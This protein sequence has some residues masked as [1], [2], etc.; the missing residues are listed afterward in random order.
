[1]VDLLLIKTHHIKYRW[2]PMGLMYVAKA[3]KNVG[4]KVKILDLSLEKKPF[5]FLRKQLLN[6][7]PSIVGVGGMYCEFEEIRQ[8]A[9]VTRETLPKTIVVVGGPLTTALLKEILQDKNIDLV[10]LCEGELT[11]QDLLGF[12]DGKTKLEDIKGIVFRKDGKLF[13]TQKREILDINLIPIPAWE[14]IDVP[15]YISR[16]DN[17]FGIENLKMLNI[18]PQRGC[19]YSCVFCD[20]N[21][22]GQ[23]WRPRDPKNIVDEMLF[24]KE[25]YKIEAIMF[26]DDIFDVNKKWVYSFIEELKK[27]NVNM[28]WGCSSRVNHSDYHLYKAMKEVGCCYI[29]YGVEFGTNEMLEK[30]N[31]KTTIEQIKKAIDIAHSAGLRVI[32]GYMLGMLDETEEQIKKTIK[33]AIET[34]TEVATITVVTPIANTVLFDLA[35]KAGKINKNT[36]WWKAT[37]ANALINLTQDVSNKRLAYL[38]SKTYW[39]LFWTRPNR[40]FPK[41]FCKLMQHSFYI[42]RPI[43]G[44]KFINFIFWLDN[45]RKRLN[46]RLP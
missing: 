17:W 9:K 13:Y 25:N 34:K 16:N 29:F 2:L 27:R 18:V 41:W 1:M 3:A 39:M 20:K 6:L 26:L 14:E 5:Y 22:F 12:L 35:V 28:Y 44:D 33:F 46:L 40:R 15:T 45:I 24:L 11:I 31:K 7:K 42:L 21:V 19:P 37:R 4:A 23:V 30:A 38:V 36:T 10:S 8:I 32:A 43:S